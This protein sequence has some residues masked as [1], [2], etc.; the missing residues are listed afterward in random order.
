M[1]RRPLLPIA[2]ASL[3]SAAGAQS[4]PTDP[5]LA[6]AV[7]AFAALGDDTAC[8]IE[9]T[10]PR[11]QLRV[12]HR[13]DAPLFVGSCIK[14]FILAA[15]LQE[16]E[17]GR[18]SLDE[19]LAVDDGARSPVSPVLG[20][21]TGTASA[22]T[23]LE[24]MI[25]HSDNTATDIAIRRVGAARV[26]EVIAKAGLAQTRI[27]ESTRVMIATLL[28]EPPGQDMAWPAISAALDNMS[29]RTLRPVVNPYQ[30]MVSTGRDLVAWY[31][32]ALRG[33]YFTTA[34][35][36]AEFKRIQSMATAMPQLA[37]TDVMAY[38]KG[39]SISWNG[40]QA[41]AVGGQ[42]VA[43]PV[44]ATFYF[45]INWAGDDDSMAPMAQRVVALSK[46]AMARVPVALA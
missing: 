40:Q 6:E 41:L 28:G 23:V 14:T 39:G 19:R 43:G 46:A 22:R 26:R 31:E 5:G 25:A 8:L 11:G 18:L 33:R 13:E 10:S 20:E 27:P 30:T 42:M 24:A 4:L 29:G 2:L 32:A 44:R 16:V 21:L 12:A 38:G 15:W 35:S 1:R 37:P 36:L 34:A 9:A 3:A 17:A 7:R 45:A